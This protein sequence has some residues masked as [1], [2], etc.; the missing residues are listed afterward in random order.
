MKVDFR[1]FLYLFW[2]L[3]LIMVLYVYFFQP[4]AFYR[5]FETYQGPGSPFINNP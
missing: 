4:A 5:M 3:F 2:I 1:F